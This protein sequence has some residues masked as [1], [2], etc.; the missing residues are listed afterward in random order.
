MNSKIGIG[1]NIWN[2]EK[3]IE[4]TLKSLVNQ[5]YKNIEI[6]ILDNKSSDDTQQI[7]KKFINKNK[8]NKKKIKLI[9][10]KKRRNISESQNYILKNCLKKFKYS[11]IAND[12]DIYD[13]NYIKTLFDLISK[14]KV[15][16]VYSFKNK[17][18]E[19]GKI[20][21]LKNF[22]TYGKD[23]SYFFNTLKFIIFREHYKI[24]FGLYET[25]KYLELMKYSKVY[26]SSKSNWD[27][28]SMIYF[29]LNYK[30]TYTK[31]KLFYFCEKNRS[32]TDKIRKNIAFTEFASIFKIFFYQ[33][34]FIQQV[35]KIIF[36]NKKINLILKFLLFVFLIL[37][38]IQKSIS[39]IIRFFFK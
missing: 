30:L 10:D 29:L 11:L 4:K 12:D 9:I 35:S 13:K 5:T 3:T 25:E 1:L 34:N 22:P 27:N 33:Y 38:S 2:G 7:I 23:D 19:N 8:I 36:K 24:S 28:V 20:Y 39:Y 32:Q 6:I 18:D 21:Y 17:I 14:N 37:S 15:N 26:D 31:K 16:M